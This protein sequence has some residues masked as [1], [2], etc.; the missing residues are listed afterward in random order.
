MSPPTGLRGLRSEA[1]VS[2]KILHFAVFRTSASFKDVHRRKK[3]MTDFLKN[4]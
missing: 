2:H 3:L 4:F 1:I